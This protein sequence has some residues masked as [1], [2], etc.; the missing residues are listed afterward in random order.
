MM[1]GY[2]KVR[3]DVILTR[4]LRT[5]GSEGGSAVIPPR[6]ALRAHTLLDTVP[7]RNIHHTKKRDL[8]WE[9]GGLDE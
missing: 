7:Q 1:Y 5:Q 3:R 9:A 2:H 6:T 8:P 4:H